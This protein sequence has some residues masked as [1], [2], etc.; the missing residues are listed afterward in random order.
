MKSKYS[1]STEEMESK[2]E[3]SIWGSIDLAFD[4]VKTREFIPLLALLS[5]NL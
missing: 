1:E 2:L 3:R 5:L 4:V